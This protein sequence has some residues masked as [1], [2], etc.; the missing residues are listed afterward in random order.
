MLHFCVLGLTAMKEAVVCV[1]SE[2]TKGLSMYLLKPAYDILVGL[3]VIKMY[4]LLKYIYI[5]NIYY[6]YIYILH[7][8]T[9]GY[10]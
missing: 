7:T 4:F 1:L 3:H 8:H 10:R 2:S 5:Y 9:Y 6:I